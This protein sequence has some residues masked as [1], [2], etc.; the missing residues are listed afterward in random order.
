LWKTGGRGDVVVRKWSSVFGRMEKW[1]VRRCGG[2]KMVNSSVLE[3]W[4]RGRDG[5]HEN[6]QLEGKC[7]WKDGKLEAMWW[8]ENGQ[9]LEQVFLEGWKKGGRGDVVA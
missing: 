8:R 9:L 5:L 6:G 2:T 3:G 7:S 1:R 4:K